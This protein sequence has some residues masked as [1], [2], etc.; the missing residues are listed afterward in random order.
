MD[1]SWTTL[2]ANFKR[3]LDPRTPHTYVAAIELG[4]IS[5]QILLCKQILVESH[6]ILYILTK[7]VCRSWRDMSLTQV[8]S[9][10]FGSYARAEKISGLKRFGGS[11]GRIDIIIPWT[12]NSKF[13]D[14]LNS[15]GDIFKLSGSRDMALMQ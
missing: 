14:R 4:P 2:W 7:R 11:I 9:A 13:P 1:S 8:W 15:R 5:N 12:F 10:Q 6:P 3:Q